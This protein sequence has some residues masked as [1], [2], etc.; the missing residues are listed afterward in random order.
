MGELVSAF[1]HLAC[2]S[3]GATFDIEKPHL[4]CE[5]CGGLLDPRYDYGGLVR[6]LDR[7]LARRNMGIWR[8]KELFPLTTDRYLVSLGEGDKQNDVIGVA[9]NH[10]GG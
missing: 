1:R 7:I 9:R 6:S 3:C 8:W 10:C 2:V 5:A 4:L